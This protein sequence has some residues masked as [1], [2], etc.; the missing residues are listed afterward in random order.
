V[1]VVDDDPMILQFVC[2]ALAQA[3]Y[4]VQSAANGEEA[5]SAYAAAAAD[6]FRLV[7]S[8]VLM[9]EVNG[10]DLARRLLGRDPGVRVLFMTGYAA[11]EFAQQELAGW[12]FDLLSKPF[13]TEGLL[14]AVRTAIER[15][16]GRPGGRAE[17]TG[18]AR[19]LA[20]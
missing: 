6:P 2:G 8:D 9:P 12:P 5:L 16:A 15:P 4:R 1:L 10:V 3:G 7:L 17:A 14:R 20:R 11:G 19:A 18:E 13:R